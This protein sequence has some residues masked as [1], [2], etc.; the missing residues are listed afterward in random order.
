MEQVSFFSD[1]M[2]LQTL[3]IKYKMQ[4]LVNLIRWI[5]WEDLQTCNQFLL[6][7]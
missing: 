3:Q 4:I 5:L 1:E 6:S 7:M 2:T